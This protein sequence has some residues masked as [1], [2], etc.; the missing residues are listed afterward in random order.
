[1]NSREI[2]HLHPQMQPLAKQFK[3]RCSHRLPTNCDVMFTSTYRSP[4]S[5][6]ELWELGRTVKSHVGPWTVEKPLGS[7]VTWAKPGQSK[8]NFQLPDG[9]PASL[10]FDIVPLRYGKPV[11]GTGGNGI[12]DD[13]TD[14]LT[15]DL[16]LWMRIAQIGK[17]LGL[18][19]AGD[20]PKGKREFPHFQIS[21]PTT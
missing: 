16:E 19:W 17:E 3:M 5:Q 2:K 1:M 20:W 13:S 8:H 6:A 18:E 15:D 7:C 4:E 10:A 21:L 12:D 9:T 14:D 11:W